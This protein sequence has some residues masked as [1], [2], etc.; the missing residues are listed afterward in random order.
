MT[1]APATLRL[2]VAAVALSLLAGP[3]TAMPDTFLARVE[4]LASIETLN[5]EILASSSA[6]RALEHWCQIHAMAADPKVHAE[7]IRGPDRPLDEA[8]R[9]RLGLSADE[10]VRYRHVRLVCGGHVLSEAD[11]WYVPSRLAPDMNRVLDTTD[12][13]F[14]KAVAALRFTRQTFAVD[15]IWSPL[16]D[17]WQIRP[18]AP[19]DPDAQ[20]SIPRILFT[21]H[22][23]LRDAA[24]RPFSEVAEH[25]TNELLDFVRPARP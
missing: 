3:A 11:N 12:T 23:V 16:P 1:I 17:D 18:P 15:G 20:L 24:N 5:A 9:Q 4:T 21:H 22:A 14:G 10:P 6:T 25:Y 7:L 19:D 13:P 2:S 8:G